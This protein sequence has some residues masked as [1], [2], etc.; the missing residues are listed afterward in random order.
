MHLLRPN[1]PY[2]KIDK[3]N[4]HP[5]TAGNCSQF[6]ELSSKRFK[7][8]TCKGFL[9]QLCK[10]VKHAVAYPLEPSLGVWYMSERVLQIFLSY[11]SAIVQFDNLSPRVLRKRRG[12]WSIIGNGA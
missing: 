4:Q 9:V 7:L 12:T 10:Y 5:Q 8:F 11:T 2:T 1:K 3:A 6:G